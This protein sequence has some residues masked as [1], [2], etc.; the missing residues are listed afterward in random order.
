M[1]SNNK[2]KGTILNIV[3]SIL[4]VEKREGKRK[5]TNDWWKEVNKDCFSFCMAN[6]SSLL[7]LYAWS[8]SSSLTWTK[9]TASKGQTTCFLQ[10]SPLLVFY[11]ENMFF[12][13]QYKVRTILSS[14][15]TQF[16]YY[17]MILLSILPES[18]L[19]NNNNSSDIF[20][21][22]IYLEYF[23]ILGSWLSHVNNQLVFRS[24]LTTFV[25]LTETLSLLEFIVKHIGTKSIIILNLLFV[26]PDPKILSNFSYSQF[27]NHLSSLNSEWLSLH[28]REK[29]RLLALCT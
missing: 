16:Y 20:F 21:S 1:Q 9:A 5:V 25:I 7:H 14:W 26:M 4:L 2:R 29:S 8:V 27:V 23:F 28:P 19:S 12:G 3:D 13:V 18:L 24:H 15:W 11:F 17:E 10:L 22:L 6:T